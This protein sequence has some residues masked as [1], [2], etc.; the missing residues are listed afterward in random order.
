MPFVLLEIFEWVKE[1]RL[2]QLVCTCVFFFSQKHR[3]YVLKGDACLGACAHTLGCVLYVCKSPSATVSGRQ[4]VFMCCT[5]C[6]HMSNATLSCVVLQ[7]VCM[8]PVLLSARL[9]TCAQCH[10]SSCVV[11][12]QVTYATLSG[13]CALGMCA[14]GTLRLSLYACAWCHIRFM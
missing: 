7:Y 13:K 14:N 9:W 1:L 10:T 8:C 5:S 11:C 4:C 12:V 3:G 6:L 2:Y